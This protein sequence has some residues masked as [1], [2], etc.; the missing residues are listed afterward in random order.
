MSDSTPQRPDLTKHNSPD[1]DPNPFA[2]GGPQQQAPGPGYTEPETYRPA[3]QQP[4]SGQPGFAQPGFGQ[5]GFGQPG[6]GQ[7]GFGQPGFGQPGYGQPGYGQPTYE[8]PGFGPP[9]YEQ[10]TYE[11]PGYGP[12]GFQQPGYPPPGFQQPEYQQ[13]GYGPAGNPQ[14]G[15]QPPDANYQQ[16]GAQSAM[17]TNPQAY[18]M[19]TPA[20]PSKVLAILSLVLGVVGLMLGWIPIIGLVFAF[21]ALVG[22]IMGIVALVQ[23][24]KGLAAGRGLAIGG[25]ATSALAIIVSIVVFVGTVYWISTSDA[26]PSTSRESRPSVSNDSGLTTDVDS[27]M[28]NDLTVTFGTPVITGDSS[29]PDTKVP[30]TLTNKSSFPASFLL[31]VIA[32]KSG[33][34]VDSDSVSTGPVQPGAT[35]HDDAFTFVTDAADLEGA[36]FSVRDAMMVRS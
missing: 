30:V 3:D 27:I 26:M 1:G 15:Y 14:A 25:I 31:T 29:F 23:I 2:A 8:Q 4:G 18:G 9:T 19:Y 11:Q 24:R 6:S 21:I 17:Y 16:P 33:Q 7:P 32:T 28:A 35:V 5:P 20:G 12:S 36:T 13:A 10:P 34:E 22:L